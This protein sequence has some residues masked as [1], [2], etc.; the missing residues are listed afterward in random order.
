MTSILLANY[1]NNYEKRPAA[2]NIAQGLV[3]SV[4]LQPPQIVVGLDKNEFSECV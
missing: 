4:T 2:G 1:T 3:V